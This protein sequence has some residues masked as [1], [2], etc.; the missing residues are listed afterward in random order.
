M[1]ISGQ[2]AENNLEQKDPCE[3]SSVTHEFIKVC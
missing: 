2:M 3:I 1:I